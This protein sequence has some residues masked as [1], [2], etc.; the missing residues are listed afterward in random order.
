MFVVT[1]VGRV[2]GP[3]SVR[4]FSPSFNACVYLWACAHVCV[5]TC[6]CDMCVCAHVSVFTWKSVDNSEY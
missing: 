5:C 2:L 6:E 3:V 4:M 1:T